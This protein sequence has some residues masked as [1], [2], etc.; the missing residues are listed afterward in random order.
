MTY[1]FPCQDL[2]LAG[3]MKG[4][5]KN[6]GTRSGL[7]WEVERLLNECKELPQIL[8]MENVIQV[9]SKKNKDD[10]HKW[11]SFLQ[12][13]GY[14]NFYR[15]LNA[16]HYGIPQNR[17]RCF[18]VSILGDYGYKFPSEIE[19][20]LRLK[21]ML[22]DEVD[23]KYYLSDKQIRYITD[24]N[25]VALKGGR[26]I[27][28]RVINPGIAKTISCRGA[29]EQRADVTN[30]VLN[31]DYEMSV[32]DFKEQYF[33]INEKTIK[34]YKEA[35]EGDGV[36]INR[37]HQK[38]GCVQH[39]M[40]QTIKTTPND[41]GVVVNEPVVCEERCDEG[42]RFFK[43]NICGTIR[44]KDSGGDKRIIESNN[45]RIRKLTPKECYRLMGFNDEDFEKAAQV[46]SNAQLYKQA[47][48][49]IVVNVLMAI[50]KQL[51]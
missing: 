34:G 21:D 42:L 30:F 5:E 44:T 26:D 37:P 1:S 14:T 6:S 19:L 33:K 18:M 2:S 27:N 46:N 48:N 49:S 51:L 40:I 8:L 38:R 45:L 15:D 35:Y 17:N 32:K 29:A 7:L 31:Q 3:N 11:L 10:F 9:H 36:Y 23:E 20:T 12:S 47:G 16:K 25:D 28:D 43:D 39:E 24:A 4:M 13:K 41:V 22:E 50:F